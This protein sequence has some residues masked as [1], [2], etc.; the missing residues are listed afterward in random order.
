MQICLRM[1]IPFHSP[2]YF[3]HPSPPICSVLFIN[4]WTQLPTR[5]IVKFQNHKNFMKHPFTTWSSMA[6]GG[7]LLFSACSDL[8]RIGDIEDIE[9]QADYAVPVFDSKTPSLTLSKPAASTSPTS[10]L[11]PT[12]FLSL[13]TNRKDQ[14]SP[15]TR[16]L[17]TFPIFPLPFSNRPPPSHST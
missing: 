14:A 16:F 12:A 8:E 9:I 1:A 2:P 17:T 6:L 3:F 11:R 10:A 7:L 15:L 5:P 4:N 13:P